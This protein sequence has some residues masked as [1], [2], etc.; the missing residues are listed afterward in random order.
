M[1]Y[2]NNGNINLSY[3]EL[4]S[5]LE[6]EIGYGTDGK[7]IKYDK[8]RLIKLYHKYIQHYKKNNHALTNNGCIINSVGEYISL[9]LFYLIKDISL[10]QCN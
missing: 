9:I 10:I 5:L 7:V 2:E 4:N 3:D 1:K 8:N 6:K